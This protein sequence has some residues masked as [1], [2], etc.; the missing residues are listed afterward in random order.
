MLLTILGD[1]EPDWAALIVRGRVAI[2]LERFRL[3]GNGT[4]ER[5]RP[6]RPARALRRC[7]APEPLA[8]LGPC[9]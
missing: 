3:L 5:R 7:R 2:R 9:G 4:P 8:R 1:Q 6:F